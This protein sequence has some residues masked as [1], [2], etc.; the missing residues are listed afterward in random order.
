MLNF[1]SRRLFLAA[2]NPLISEK[3][4]IL[5]LL[6]SLNT[7]PLILLVAMLFYLLANAKTS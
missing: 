6:S 5:C 3:V 2:L 7:S 4:L 1:S